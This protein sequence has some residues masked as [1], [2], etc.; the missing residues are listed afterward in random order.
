MA[1]PQTTQELALYEPQQTSPLVR[2]LVN[3]TDM[4]AAIREYEALKSAIIQPSDKQRIGNKD[5]IKK[6]GWLRIA[7]AFG[8]T[9]EPVREEFQTA[10][11]GSWG[12]AIV[13]RAVAPNGASMQ[14][15]GMCWSTE[16]DSRQRTRHNVR[17]H[18]YTRATNRAISN[19]VGGGEVSAEEM[20]DYVDE[21]PRHAPQQPVRR[22]SA[23]APATTANGTHNPA[24][25]KARANQLGRAKT[26]KEWG[27]LFTEYKNNLQ[28]LSAYL[29]AYE[30]SQSP[31]IP[32]EHT[33][34]AY[35]LEGLP[36][37]GMH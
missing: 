27:E 19:L 20:Q 12:Y 31:A 14:G 16:K 17:A 26:S 30:A 22:I 5:H 35:A 21:D 28:G 11:D 36:V 3:P 33:E 24:A 15:D 10:E 34:I 8:L 32:D 13:V 4:L 6:S 9:V 37:S 7:R 2:P 23:P 18:A 25:L 1:Q 29:D